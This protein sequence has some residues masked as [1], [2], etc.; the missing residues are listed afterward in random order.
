[1]HQRALGEPAKLHLTD[2]ASLSSGTKAGTSIAGATLRDYCFLTD[3]I[4]SALD[5]L[6]FLLLLL[7]LLLLLFFFFLYFLFVVNFVIH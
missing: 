6:C 2:P 5:M 3:P 1:M 4:P 7:L